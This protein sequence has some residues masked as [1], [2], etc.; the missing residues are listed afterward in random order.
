MARDSRADRDGRRLGIAGLAHHDNVG[1]LAQQGAQTALKGQA[2]NVVD[3][4]LVDTGQVAF[5]GVLNRRDIDLPFGDGLQDHVQRRRF[6]GTCRPGQV[7]DA[8]GA[9]EQR[10]KPLVGRVVHAEVVCVFNVGIRRQNTQHGLF[11]KDRRQNRDT[12]VDVGAGLETCAEVA[13]LRDAV[14]GNVKVGHD[15]DTRDERLMQ[16]AL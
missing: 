4:R 3:L 16:C 1:I 5:H 6:A 13:V 12:D 8:V 10:L 2:R 15:L 7:D 9:V 14:L 11:A